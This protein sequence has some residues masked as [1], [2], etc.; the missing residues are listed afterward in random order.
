MP[1]SHLAGE[2]NVKLGFEK[3]GR[4]RGVSDEEEFPQISPRFLPKWSATGMISVIAM[5]GIPGWHDHA[6]T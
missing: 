3:S 2:L 5:Q 4:I 6:E 1:W